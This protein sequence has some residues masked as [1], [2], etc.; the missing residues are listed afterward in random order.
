MK[1]HPLKYDQNEKLVDAEEEE[2]SPESQFA[3]T[4]TSKYQTIGKRY[5]IFARLNLLM[6]L[7]AIYN[8]VHQV[9]KNLLSSMEEK[10]KQI[11]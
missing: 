4:F 10:K 11:L 1:N 9:I 8:I 7:S 2:N 3:K 6:K 5:K